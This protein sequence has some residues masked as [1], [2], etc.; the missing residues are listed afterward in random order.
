MRGVVFDP[1]VMRVSL[2][3]EEAFGF[4]EAR[5]VSFE[6]LFGG[7]LHAALDRQHPRDLY[8]VRLLYENEGLTDLA[9]RGLSCVSRMFRPTAA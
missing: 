2:S 6:D 9:V 3:V 8:D 4:V 5:I 7:K 1:K